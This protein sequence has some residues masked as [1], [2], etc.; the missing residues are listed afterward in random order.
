[1]TELS[2]RR[3]VPCEGGI[4]PLSRAAA[5]E[6]LQ[7]LDEERE[8]LLAA[9]AWCGV[10]LRCRDR[11]LQLVFVLKTYWRLRGLLEVGYRITVEALGR[12]PAAELSFARCRV[13]C[14]A[15]QLAYF[16]GRYEQA[17]RDLEESRRLA[18]DIGDKGRMAAVLQ[19]LGMTYVALGLRD[20]A[21]STYES[22]VALAQDVGERRQ[23]AAALNA[24]AQ[25]HHANGALDDAED[26]DCPVLQNAR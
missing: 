13:L 9:H 3:C 11:G 20:Q 6:V 25:L 26:L 4:A 22:A 17:R 7:R 23:L 1:M 14:D 5:E 19:P 18:A 21:R 12:V 10:V 8:N 16:S 2:Q 24:L 15:G